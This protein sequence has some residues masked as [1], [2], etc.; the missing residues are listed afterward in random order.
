MAS[1][2]PSEISS[3]LSAFD[4]DLG[5]IF[6]NVGNVAQ[7]VGS[8]YDQITGKS[9]NVPGQSGQTYAQSPTVA[10]PT[11]TTPT[12]TTPSDRA[13]ESQILNSGVALGIGAVVLIGVLLLLK[14]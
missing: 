5:D 12:E 13:S 10:T 8:I 7:T 14:D 9:Q 2:V 3:S 6:T 4:G 1:L 11:E